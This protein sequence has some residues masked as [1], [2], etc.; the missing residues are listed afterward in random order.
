MFLLLTFAK[1]MK[2]ETGIGEVA[3]V[4]LA[5]EASFAEKRLR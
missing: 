5:R 3:L 2:L 4:G 1:D